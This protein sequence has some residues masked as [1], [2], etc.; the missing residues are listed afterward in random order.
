VQASLPPHS[1][2]VTAE[3]RA[4]AAVPRK[5]NR[6]NRAFPLCSRVVR[7]RGGTLAVLAAA[8]AVAGVVAIDDDDEGA[9]WHGW[10][11]CLRHWQW[12]AS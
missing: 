8:L 4:T 6:E 1:D 12:R 7:R 10:R 2:R 9:P 3:A 5:E 11:C